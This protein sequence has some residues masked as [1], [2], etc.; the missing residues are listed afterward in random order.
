MTPPKELGIAPTL[1][2]YNWGV[3]QH[4][5]I[6]FDPLLWILCFACLVISLEYHCHFLLILTVDYNNAIKE[7][8]YA[9]MRKTT[10]ELVPRLRGGNVVGRV[11][12]TN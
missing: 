10:W 2:I 12:H 8:H 9:L 5:Y 11:L 7:E 1:Y 6:L 3:L 4:I